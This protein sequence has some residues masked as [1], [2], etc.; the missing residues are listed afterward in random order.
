MHRRC[1]SVMIARLAICTALVAGCSDIPRDPEGTLDRIRAQQLFKVGVIEAHSPSDDWQGRS[2][3]FV[4]RL[5]AR[6][7][8]R[9]EVQRGAAEPLL[10]KVEHGE[11]DL[12]IGPLAPT[13]PWEGH[14]SVL[15]ALAEH[16]RPDGHLRL[17][18]VARNGENAWI[19]LLHREALAVRAG[20]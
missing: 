20:R 16:V 17:A 1:T 18:P 6:T 4:R 7:G 9:A 11:L 8:A 2:D 13:S 5:A 15:P 19:G 3:Q 14:V 10:M 12:V